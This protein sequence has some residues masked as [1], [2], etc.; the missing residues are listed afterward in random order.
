MQSFQFGGNLAAG[1]LMSGAQVR[2][3]G[4]KSE[5]QIYS[6]QIQNIQ[7]GTISS[8]TSSTIKKGEKTGLKVWS[9][10]HRLLLKLHVALVGW[11]QRWHYLL[12]SIWPARTFVV[13]V[14]TL[15]VLHWSPVAFPCLLCRSCK[16]I[17]PRSSA[18][19]RLESPW[20]LGRNLAHL[21]R[22]LRRSTQTWGSNASPWIWLIR[23]SPRA[24]C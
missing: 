19:I 23:D 12:I 10:R 14:Y 21:C 24:H 3:G 20:M 11:Q 15:M 7:M 9:W 22:H 16:N 17:Q 8:H 18:H 13:S 6:F 4:W 2:N 1:F 5:L